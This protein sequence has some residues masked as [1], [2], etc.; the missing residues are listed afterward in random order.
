ML[1]EETIAPTTLELLKTLMNDNALPDFRLVGGTALALQM[2]HRISVDLDLFTDTPFDVENCQAILQN[3]YGFI[4]TYIQHQTLKGNIGNVK[5]DCIAHQYPWIKPAFEAEGIRLASLEDIC[6][7]KLNAI[8]GNGTRLKDFID[9]AW[10]SSRF[11]FNE[12][13]GFY[14]QKY[15]AN[16]IIPEKAITFFEDINFNEPIRF[17][18]NKPFEWESYAKTIQKMVDKPDD[19]SGSLP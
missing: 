10:L 13:L 8:A 11:S 9:I 2:G 3:N 19:K 5:I 18:G 17:T 1:H 4:P 12:M 6:A 7:M 14:Y 16:T 15:H